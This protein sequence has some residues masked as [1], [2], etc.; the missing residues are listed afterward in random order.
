VIRNTNETNI[1]AYIDLDGGGNNINISTGIGFLDHMIHAL[2]KHGRMDINI[3]CKGDIYIDD[4]HSAED[5]AI[6]LGEAFDKA[7]GARKGINRYGSAHAPLD[8]SLSL[9]VV[10]ISSRPYATIHL[11][12]QREKVG[13]LSCEMVSHVLR[14]FAQAARITIHVN[15]LTGENDHHKIESAFKALALAIRQAISIDMNRLNDV[16]STKGVLA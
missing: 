11:N 4:H 1:E 10:D 13:D 5:C 2:G 6:A 12:L 14:S 3:K 16:P 7:L 9:A 8:E 15:V